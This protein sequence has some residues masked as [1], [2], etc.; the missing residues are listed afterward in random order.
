[1]PDIPEEEPKKEKISHS[2][3]KEASQEEEELGYSLEGEE[4]QP[5]RVRRPKERVS[6]YPLRRKPKTGIEA[7]KKY[8]ITGVIVLIIAYFMIGMVAVSKKDF[9]TNFQGVSVTIDGI[10]KDVADNKVVV[11]EAVAGIPD[12]IIELVGGQV[13]E[14][15]KCIH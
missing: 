8:I 15:V 10:K 3:P 14:V 13:E 12:T 11:K 4:E 1:M 2:K 6:E 5:V 7:Y 9:T